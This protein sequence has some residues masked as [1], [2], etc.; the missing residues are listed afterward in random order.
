MWIYSK[1]YQKILTPDK[2][3]AALILLETL[4]VKL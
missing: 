3:S 2:I 1:N 4:I